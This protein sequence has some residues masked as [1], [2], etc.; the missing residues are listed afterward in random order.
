MLASQI[1]RREVITISQ[2]ASLYEAA[3]MLVHHGFNAL[4]VVDEQGKLVGMVGLRDIL[5]VPFPSRMERWATRYETL[6]EKAKLLRQTLVKKVMAKRLV[7][8]SPDTPVEE[9]L[10]TI[11]NRGVHP[12]PIVEDGRLSGIVGRYEIIRA[13]LELAG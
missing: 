9:I 3:Q 7:A 13:M 12:I 11:I 8:Y 10:A 4:P 1:M 2:D 5:R 6:E